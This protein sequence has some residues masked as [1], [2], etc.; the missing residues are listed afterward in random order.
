M[1]DLIKIRFRKRDTIEYLDDKSHLVGM[2]E[3]YAR[4]GIVE[5]E[6]DGEGDYDDEYD[7]T[8]D[9][10]IVNVRDKDDAIGN[11]LHKNENRFE[12]ISLQKKTKTRFLAIRLTGKQPGR[13]RDGGDDEDEDDE[14]DETARRRRNQFVENPEVVRERMA[15]QRA[16]WQQR[17]HPH[18]TP[19]DQP[20]DVVGSARG[21]GQSG[22][23]VHNRRVK[24]TNKASQGNH[25]RR[26][27]AAQKANRGLLS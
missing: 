9:D 7:D 24:D 22:N 4:L 18:R 25:N 13:Y 5:D 11:E 6:T 15:Q 8:Y 10:G 1:I 3:H 16:A 17:H 27:R 2:T 12:E 19:A 20:R 21:R 14:D 26:N 23:V